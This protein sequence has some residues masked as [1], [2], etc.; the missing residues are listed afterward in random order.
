MTNEANEMKCES[1]ANTVTCSADDPH[2][3]TVTLWSG[4]ERIECLN[5]ATLSEKAGRHCELILT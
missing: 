1:K 5:H 2:W 3:F 4:R